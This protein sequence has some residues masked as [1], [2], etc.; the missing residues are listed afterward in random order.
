MDHPEY[1]VCQANLEVRETLEIRELLENQA[2]M[3]KMEPVDPKGTLANQVH[4]ECREDKA[5]MVCLGLL[6]Q[7]VPWWKEK[8]FQGLLDN[9]VWM[10]LQDL[11]ERQV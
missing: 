4:K 7:L 11:L 6:V 1:Q 10:V 2:E 8:R 3:V 9:Q 5:E